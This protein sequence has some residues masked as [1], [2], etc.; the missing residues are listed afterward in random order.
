MRMNKVIITVFFLLM[1]NI[2]FKSQTISIIDS[3]DAKPVSFVEVVMDGKLF[4]AD[5][6]GKF[7][8]H[9]TFD[10]LVLR[11]EGYY[12]KKV[13][14]FTGKILLSQKVVRIPE[15]RLAKREKKTFGFPAKKNRSVR[16]SSITPRSVEL[17]YLI[18]NPY[19]KSGILKSMMLPMKKVF[20][21][22]NARLFIRF[23]PI[24]NGV[25]AKESIDNSLVIIGLNQMIKN[26]NNIPLE[27][28]P[29]S[30]E[31]ILLSVQVIEEFGTSDVNQPI[32]SSVQFF[33]SS[34]KVPF[35]IRN[36]QKEWKRFEEDFPLI[37]VSFEGRF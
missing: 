27:N 2:S 9:R 17:G 22:E 4:Y 15:V 29:I 8:V 28:I 10:E 7:R 30:E 6:L 36:T 31:G 21:N 35:F 26:K 33:S 16:L 3:L 13:N 14:V 11:K 19:Q 32:K 5:S 37:G 20:D 12:D 34:K 1:V 25:P 24:E 23:Y 18:E